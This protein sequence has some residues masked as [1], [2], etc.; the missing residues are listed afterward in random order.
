M[1]QILLGDG[2]RCETE[3]EEAP[4]SF[5]SYRNYLECKVS[6]IPSDSY[7]LKVRV[8]DNHGYALVNRSAKSVDF[9]TK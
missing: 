6:D 9:N 3:D 2:Y 5:W 4:R 8:D 7:Q 1:D